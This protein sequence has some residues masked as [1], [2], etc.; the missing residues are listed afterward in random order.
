MQVL[1]CVRD[2][3]YSGESMVITPLLLPSPSA[4]NAKQEQFSTL[5]TSFLG[6]QLV[7][8]RGLFPSIF[9][10]PQRHV[11]RRILY[12]FLII[13]PIFIFFSH[14]LFRA[15]ESVSSLVRGFAR[16]VT[17]FLLYSWVC[18]FNTFLFL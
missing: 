2:L 10:S 1:L 17:Y 9:N 12:Y 16:D 8:F 11:R 18:I 7:L 14:P 13:L 5:L 4:S 3:N 6:C 15:R